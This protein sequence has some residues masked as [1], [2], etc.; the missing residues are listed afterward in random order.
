MARKK[1]WSA[2]AK[3]RVRSYRS[4]EKKLKTF[5][6]KYDIKYTPVSYREYSAVYEN[7]V[8]QVLEGERK[9]VGDVGSYMIKKENR[10]I[11][12]YEKYKEELYKRSE[13]MIKRGLSPVDGLEK[14]YSEFIQRYNEYYHDLKEEVEAGTRKAVGDIVGR[15]VSDQVYEISSKQYEAVYN[16][17]IEWNAAHPEEAIDLGSGNML[18]LQMKIR[19]GEFLEDEGWWD[20]VKAKKREFIA[21]GM[22][23]REANREIRRTL[24]GSP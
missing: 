24:F 19:Q 9:S 7:R 12:L 23:N 15:I 21:K 11:V 1:T 5:S 6:K 20:L 4:Y 22:S 16:A 3:A 8:K 17:I 14:S 13:A 2:A 10:P 18:S